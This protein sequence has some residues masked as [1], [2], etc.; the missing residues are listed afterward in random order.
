MPLTPTDEGIVKKVTQTIHSCGHIQILWCIHIHVGISRLTHTVAH[1][2][3]IVP[4][5][6]V[7][8]KSDD[9]GGD[10]VCKG[11]VS[12]SHTLSLM[13][14]G[15]LLVVETM[16]SGAG[17]ATERVG[18]LVAAG[19]VGS[20]VEALEMMAQMELETLKGMLLRDDAWRAGAVPPPR[21]WSSSGGFS[22]RSSS[23]WPATEGTISTTTTTRRHSRASWSPG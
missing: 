10:D 16:A 4:L 14:H 17:V 20:L 9:T 5:I 23:L 2:F 6:S 13:T 7:H 15:C 1:L 21:R 3:A 11:E 19:R 12:Q 18:S 22:R 8:L